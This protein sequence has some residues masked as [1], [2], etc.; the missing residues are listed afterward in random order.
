[1]KRRVNLPRRPA[2]AKLT[3]RQKA[4]FE[5][6]Q[7]IAANKETI[8]AAFERNE[9]RSRQSRVAKLWGATKR[10]CKWLL[11]GILSAWS[12]R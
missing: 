9:A 1:M 3:P 4:A 7:K 8:R 10:A 12:G 5:A 11:I 6:S 2:K